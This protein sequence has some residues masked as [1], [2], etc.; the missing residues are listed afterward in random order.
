LKIGKIFGLILTNQTNLMETNVFDVAKYILEQLGSLSTMKLQKLVY[1]S[2]AWS[3][4]WDEKPL[5][6]NQIEA[7]ANGPV[8]PDL[9][10]FHKGMFSISSAHINVPN[11][12]LSEEQIDTINSVLRD[13]ASRPA[14]WLIELTHMEDPWIDAR[15]G[16][17]PNERG[18]NPITHA[19]ISEYYSSL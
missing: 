18:S 16:L 12:R 17:S 8:V 3:L 4:V 11:D 9:Y 2:Q 6:D 10:H 7:W 15:A 19:A 14:Q 13:Y 5:F 1:Y